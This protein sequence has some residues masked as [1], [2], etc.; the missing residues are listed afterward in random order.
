MLKSAL[1][2]TPP[3]G[4]TEAAMNKEH[5]L[6]EIKRTAEANAGVPLGTQRF[7][8]QTGIKQSDWYGKYW[9]R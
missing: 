1:S 2:Y 8:K 5:I 4:S 3:F 9:V 6:S 7:F